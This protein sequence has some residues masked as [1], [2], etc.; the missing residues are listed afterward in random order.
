MVEAAAQQGTYLFAQ[1]ER[2]YAH[3]SVGDIRGKGLLAGIELVQ[4]KA[5]K[6]PY[7]AERRVADRLFR[8]CL[9]RGAIIYPGGGMMDGV[10]G[11]QFLLCP[12]F[13]VT[14]EQIDALV[15]A[16]DDALTVLEAEMSAAS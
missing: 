11:D 8:L 16:L 1:L 2:L 12:P 5:T 15:D 9:E 4:D 6:A 7:P 3:P 14:R 13:I 10:R